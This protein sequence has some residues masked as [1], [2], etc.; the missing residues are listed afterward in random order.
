MNLNHMIVGKYLLLLALQGWVGVSPPDAINHAADAWG[1]RC[2][3]Y[4]IRDIQ[5][6]TKV[7]EAMQMQVSTSAAY[8][9]L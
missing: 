1:L 9:L 6:P 7:K 4:E 5:L 8:P 2:L 3:R